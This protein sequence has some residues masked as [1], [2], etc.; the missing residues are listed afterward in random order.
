MSKVSSEIKYECEFTS[1]DFSELKS[2]FAD[3]RSAVESV[4]ISHENN[5]GYPPSLCCFQRDM[6]NL[7][8]VYAK[9]E[10]VGGVK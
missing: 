2:A 1:D 10:F 5:S 3:L 4:I 7:F 8:R 6:D 9:T